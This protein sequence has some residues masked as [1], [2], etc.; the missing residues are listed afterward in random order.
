MGYNSFLDST[1]MFA[2]FGVT[3]TDEELF[4]TRREMWA[5]FPRDIA[6]SDKDEQK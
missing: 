3:I 2:H 1:G 4:Q 5:N 6:L